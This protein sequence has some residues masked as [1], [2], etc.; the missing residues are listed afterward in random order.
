[1]VG[2]LARENAVV[3]FKRALMR[4]QAAFHFRFGADE[5]FV[6][7]ERSRGRE[8]FVVIKRV[9][10][11]ARDLWQIKQRPAHW[12]SEATRARNCSF[13]NALFGSA[14]KA[15]QRRSSSAR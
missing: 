8:R 14:A 13:V 6:E 9:R 7:F 15:A 11:I 4:D 12:R 3:M 5:R 10:L 1:M 2:K